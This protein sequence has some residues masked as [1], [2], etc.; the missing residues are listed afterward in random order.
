MYKREGDADWQEWEP[1]PNDIQIVDEKIT[2][3]ATGFKAMD[4]FA[5]VREVKLPNKWNNDS[6]VVDVTSIGASAFAGCTGLT[7]V[8]IGNGVTSIED[9]A[10]YGCSGLTSVVIPDGVTSI[11]WYAFEDCSGLT[12]VTIGN[13][14]TSIEDYA[15]RGCSSLTSVTIPA[16]VTRIGVE[17]FC[18]CSGLTSVTIPDS[19]HSIWDYA[20]SDCSSLTS[21]E[22]EGNAPTVYG[23]NVFANVATGCK[24]IISPTA[25]DFPA[26]GETW[27]G[28]IVEV[29]S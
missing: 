24:A 10:F 18:D 3:K 23:S 7:S 17:A 8:T 4:G 27:N 29:K 26:A 14:V 12:N 25:T 28:L 15:F 2:I 9:Y 21:V 13:G 11:G 1:Q 19:V 6:E 20:F 16:N 22:F 5:D